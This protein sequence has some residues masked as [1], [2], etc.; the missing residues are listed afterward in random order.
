M[1][2]VFLSCFLFSENV[3][4]FNNPNI[5]SAL[6]APYRDT[7]LKSKVNRSPLFTRLSFKALEQSWKIQII[8]RCFSCLFP[9]TPPASSRGCEFPD[10]THASWVPS[11]S[12]LC[13]S[14]YR[15]CVKLHIVDTVSAT[16]HRN[17]WSSCLWIFTE[18]TSKCH[19]DI[20]LGLHVK[21]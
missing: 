10:Y 1:I 9:G 16:F 14:H 12:F 18:A 5:T 20:T 11:Y 4:V 2:I 19:T 21:R 7:R 15:Y 8:G 13:S 3:S 17:T 6:A